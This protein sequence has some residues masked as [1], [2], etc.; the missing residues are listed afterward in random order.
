MS[1]FYWRCSE[2]GTAKDVTAERLFEEQ[3]Y[4]SVLC[5]LCDIEMDRKPL[6]IDMSEGYSHDNA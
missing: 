3:A 6:D 5:D 2:C 1:N 4:G